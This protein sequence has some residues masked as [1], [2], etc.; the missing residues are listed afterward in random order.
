MTAAGLLVDRRFAPLFWSQVTVAFNDNLLKTGII[1]LMTFGYRTFGHEVRVLGMNAGQL[2]PLAAALLI[3]PFI[4][5]SASAGQLADQ[6]SRRSIIV[7]TKLAEL[8]LMAVAAA[9][10]AATGLGAPAVGLTV[11][12]LLLFLTGAQSAI[13][14][15]AKYSIV[16]E[17]VDETRLVTANALLQ[18]GS[19]LAILGGVI[20]A[21]SL[22][23]LPGGPFWLGGC[24]L[25]VS[26]LGYVASRALPPTPAANPGQR[27]AWL[28]VAPSLS[29]VRKLMAN[30]VLRRSV[31][32]ISWFWAFGACLLTVFPVWTR[33][34]LHGNEAL[35]TWFMALFSVGIGAGS[36]L[37]NR[38]SPQGLELGLVAVG[39]IGLTVFPFLLWVFGAPVSELSAETGVLSFL[40]TWQG[41]VVSGIVASIAASGGLFV[42]PLYA[43]LQSRAADEERGQMLA[44]NNLVSSVYILVSQAGL[45]ALGFAGISERHVFLILALVNLVGVAWLYTIIPEFLYRFLAWIIGRLMY[46]LEVTGIEK[47]PR[48]GACVIVCNH[49][50]F[51]DWLIVGGACPRPTRFVM[52]KFMFQLPVVNRFV[53]RCKAI[54][55]ASR[56]VDPELL[57]KAWDRIAEE[58]EAGN[59]VCI[60]PEGGLTR[61]GDPL[62]YRPGIEKIV[63]RTP[64]PV[65]TLAMNGMWGSFF[66]RIDGAALKAPF[67]RG[68]RSRIW[69]TV[70]E[71]LAPDEVTIERV[72]ES[73][74]GVWTRRPEK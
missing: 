50:T 45:M 57:E 7:A 61:D 38:L 16:P 41:V 74:V 3:V 49:V 32:G 30:P 42:V 34:A 71:V 29:V 13:Y 46:R 68:I 1:F 59:V 26:L 33:D 14:G 24:I 54:P 27:V 25:T 62:E 66:S 2:N 52:D 67:R 39:G 40:Q 28:S 56:K 37:C 36:L 21:G 72:R 18:M 35:A 69:L 63:E 11:L 20:T 10:F 70:H 65:V 4:L 22:V 6:M 19:Y 15:P 8:I 43:L 51:V 64:V 55:I 17:L 53:K 44:A 58:L 9:G 5:F 47:I 23:A 31:T 60:F 48:E 12:V 73:I